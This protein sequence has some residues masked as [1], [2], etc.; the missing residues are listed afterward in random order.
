MQEKERG[1]GSPMS[2][3]A[4]GILCA[5]VASL[6]AVA[7]CPVCS[8]LASPPN[9]T[10]A[11]PLNGR[12]SINQTPSFSG[13]AEAGGGEVTLRIYAGA[14]AAGAAIQ[15]FSTL[16]LSPSGIWSVGPTEPLGV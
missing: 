16:I 3:A 2:R 8:A 11:S 14:V 6:V 12:E 15:E 4:R 1:M 5:A 9:V 7:S 13:G 10:I